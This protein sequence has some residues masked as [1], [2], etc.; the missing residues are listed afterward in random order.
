MRRKKL[1][2]RLFYPVPLPDEIHEGYYGRLV[3]INAFPEKSHLLLPIVR[4]HFPADLFPKGRIS[5]IELLSYSANMPLPDFV[6]GHTLLPY[7]RAVASHKPE[8][9]HGD[10]SDRAM[11]LSAGPRLARPG[12][13]FCVACIEADHK[14]I[15]MSYW[16]RAHQLPGMYVCPE[17]DQALRYMDK[18][19]AF[20]QAPSSCMDAAH[21]INEKWALENHSNA[22]VSRFLTLSLTL[23]SSKLP[24]HVKK[25]RLV[26]AQH[27]REQGLNVSAKTGTEFLSD[28]IVS[29]F[30][31]QWLE[32]IFPGLTSK[33]VGERINQIDGVL[34]LST[35]SSSVAAYL[36]SISVLFDSEQ[37]ALAALA[38]SEFLQPVSRKTSRGQT[39]ALNI[40]LK[41]EY[42]RT[43]GNHLRIAREN[44]IELH[45]VTSSLRDSGFPNLTVKGNSKERMVEAAVNFYVR[46]HA[47]AK[48]A[49]LAGV[50]PED[51]ER[52]VR[53]AGSGL[54]LALKR[55]IRILGSTKADAPLGSNR[56][57]HLIAG[58]T[59]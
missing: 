18:V 24:F 56:L 10:A 59:E 50:N 42:I 16:R 3:R 39:P 26:L 48:S 52:V 23:A 13:Y 9:A 11:I 14:T 1:D 28:R 43:R 27:A 40:C 33:P 53:N 38:G 32:T 17:H 58:P 54:T 4:S 55:M 2:C 44:G 45:A 5:L 47:L 6:R 7:R 25:I 21:L 29:T 49:E 51:L 30:P 46:E 31:A 57:P 8:L 35:C 34:Y 12:A 36:L 19:N 15:G 20:L 37:M 41:E 22:A